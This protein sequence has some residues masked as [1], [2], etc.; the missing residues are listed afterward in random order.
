MAYTIKHLEAELELKKKSKK[1][2]TPKFA[3]QNSEDKLQHF[4]ELENSR[5]SKRLQQSELKKQ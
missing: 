5:R 4:K 2:Q 3:K 1:L